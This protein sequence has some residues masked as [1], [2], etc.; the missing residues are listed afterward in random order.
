M[1]Q[2]RRGGGQGGALDGIK[3]IQDGGPNRSGALRGDRKEGFK[4]GFKEGCKEDYKDTHGLEFSEGLPV[5]I[6]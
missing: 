3:R 4:E 5:I 2:S 1:T 6:D